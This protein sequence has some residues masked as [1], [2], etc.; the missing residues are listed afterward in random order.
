M[1]GKIAMLLLTIKVPL[2]IIVARIIIFRG[3]EHGVNVARD[4]SDSIK[5]TFKYNPVLGEKVQT[6]EGRMWHAEEKYWSVPDQDGIIEKIIEVFKGEEVYVDPALRKSAV[7]A[8]CI[9]KIDIPVVSH[10]HTVRRKP[11]PPCFEGLKIK[12]D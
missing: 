8:S 7:Q 10:P 3:R 11:I 12:G 6:I 1:R 5:M 2:S 4:G 9:T